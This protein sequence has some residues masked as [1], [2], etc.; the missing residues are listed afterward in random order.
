MM[1]KQ[2]K[3]MKKILFTFS[4]LCLIFACANPGSGPDGG[5]Y[6][7]TPPRILEMRPGLG[8]TNTTLKKIDITFD[9][10]IKVENAVEKVIV[11]PPQIEVPEIKVLGKRISVSLSDTLKPATTYTIDFSDAITDVTEGNPLGNFTYYFSTGEQLDTMEVAGHVLNAADLE[12]V[13]GILVG[14]H[15]DSTDS[16]FNTKPFERVA[17]TNGDGRFSIKGVAPGKYRIYALQ[18]M[19]GDFKRAAGER[20]AF[21]REE[22]IPSSHPA[23][24][25]DTVWRDTVT[26]DSIRAI[27]YTHYTPDDVVLLAFNEVNTKRYFLK[28]QRDVPEWFRVYFTAPSKEIP[29]IKGIN[30]D[31]RDAFLEQRSPGND[32]ITYWIKSFND[33]TEPDTLQFT[34]TYEM[35]D[36]SLAQCRMQTDT[37]QL[38]PKL[39]LARRNKMQAEE[40][41][42][43][44]KKR[45]RRHKRGD[46]SEETPPVE[47]L[48][49]V[50]PSPNRIT[51]EQNISFGFAEPITRLD[52]AAFHLYL[53]VDTLM[54][55]ADFELEKSES[56]F[57][58]YTIRGEW[59]N[60][61]KYTLMIDSAAVQGLYGKTNDNLR[62][63][64]S[65]PK[66]E[67]FGSLF[68]MLNGSDSTAVVQLMEG[69]KKVS[70]QV[71]APNGRA[72]FFYLKPG[73]YYVRL[74]CDRNGNGKWDTGD[75]AKG[76]MPEEVYYYPSALEIRA[77]WDIEQ[78]WNV[79]ALP[80]TQQK[81]SEL[82]KQ[83]GDKKNTPRNKNAERLKQLG[84]DK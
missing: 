22:I 32:T 23:T 26:I 61:Q 64:F 41:E 80:L 63:E 55:E 3:P 42:K 69:E 82:I 21:S 30:F 25:Y 81:P 36:D 60:G 17:R 34:Y 18:D 5:P 62:F 77:N 84:R 27:P 76:L 48:K 66:T 79:H 31:E 74:F 71:A 45:E 75:Y 19:D 6:D 28:T 11:S 43:W 46:Y 2:S 57:L 35:Y 4:L 44:E 49:I 72:D 59:R 9:E 13:K 39:T 53:H 33:F 12:P 73:K 78:T 8:Q 15:S 83:K 67:D 40:L 47:H 24:R 20:V 51:P 1:R 52:T 10:Y 29:T 16:A 38:V 58:G 68:F 37:L 7:E 14:L 65:V 50:G 54:Q 70:R 56:D